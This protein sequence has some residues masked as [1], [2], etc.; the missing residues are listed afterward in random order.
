M[1]NLFNVNKVLYIPLDVNA[2]GTASIHVPFPVSEII[3]KQLAY[4]DSGGG[5]TNLK[6]L[7]VLYS[8]LVQNNSLGI[9]QTGGVFPPVNPQVR[10]CYKTHQNVS[11]IF[12]FQL[13]DL[14]GNQFV[15]T[16]SPQAN[17]CVVLEFVQYYSMIQDVSI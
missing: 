14:F 12:T 3:V 10:Y 15:L 6:A 17:I 2:Q 5:Y 7:G 13:K 16:G 11:G 1:S 9:L 4:V 8:S